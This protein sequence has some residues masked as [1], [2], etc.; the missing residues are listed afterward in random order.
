MTIIIT[1]T[2][3]NADDIR[4]EF[5]KHDRDYYPIEVYEYIYD[6]LSEMGS[7]DEHTELDVIAWCCDLSE[8]TL[9]ERDFDDIDDLVS[10][11]EYKT[12]VIYNDGETVWYLAY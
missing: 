3:N 10:D 9:D 7:D 4:H 5:K 1:D 2:A 12:T 6:T 11:L 8:T